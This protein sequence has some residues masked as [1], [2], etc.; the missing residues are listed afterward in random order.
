[1]DFKGIVIGLVA[2]A[3]LGFGIAWL[4]RPEPEQKQNI[5]SRPRESADRPAERPTGPKPMYTGQDLDARFEAG[6]AEARKTAKEEAEKEVAKEREEQAGR[7]NT[8]EKQVDALKKELEEAKRAT[9]EPKNAPKTGK[10][11][12]I[13]WGKYGDD[14]ALREAKY[15][16]A[17][18][19]T[20]KMQS[21]IERVIKAQAEG[22]EPDA[23]DTADIGNNN[24]RLQDHLKK[25]LGKLPT[26]VMGNGDYT[27][28]F[29]I[30]NIVAEALKSAGKPLSP[31][32]VTRIGELGEEY[33]AAWEKSQKLYTEATF[34]VEKI[35]DEV[36][37]KQRFYD[38]LIEVLAADQ[39]EIIVNPQTHN[40][41]GAD[42]Y[43]PG[44]MLVMGGVTPL[45]QPSRENLRT[46]LIK[47]CAKN[48]KLDAAQLEGL[49]Y[50]F[51]NWFTD[52]GE[53]LN[54]VPAA[55]AEDFITPD[56]IKFGRA[57]IKA[58]KEVISALR[59]EGEAQKLFRQEGRIMLLRVALPK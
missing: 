26:N 44:L 43:S 6:K 36:E 3:A 13:R 1:M 5:P 23:E 46:E 14:A 57:Q 38:G 10:D 40:R 59:L 41:I 52:L 48:W 19:A 50:V 27:H 55:D 39:R 58:M 34:R 25:I 30:A 4:A 37:L 42:L 49:N 32:Q 20:R 51:D 35:V 47:Q 53:M 54:P 8:L 33:E 12:I 28:P 31:A 56:C 45:V 9:P 15:D 22:R 17:A 16:E 18:D 11:P 7:V 21:A 24:R 29:N 2:G